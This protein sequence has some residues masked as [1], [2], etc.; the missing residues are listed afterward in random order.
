[1]S[2]LRRPD[3]RDSAGSRADGGAAVSLAFLRAALLV[4]ILA[5]EQLVD[6]RQ[7][8]DWQFFAVLVVAAAY[9][10][11]GLIVAVGVLGRSGARALARAQPGCD[12]LILA[13]LAYTSG[14]AF[15]DV[16]KAFFVIP[17]AA[18]FSE[19][20]RVTATWSLLAVA[21]FTL[22][23]VLAGGHPVGAQNS[24]QRLT[25]NQDL[26]LAW[27]GAAATML[28]V[29]LQRRTSRVE[30]LAA[31]RQ[32][33]VTHAIESVERERSRLASAL[34]DS[35][36]QNLIA[37][38][39]DLR[40]A[41][42]SG[43]PESFGRV[44]EA[45]DVTIAELREEIFNLHPHV[46]DHVGLGAALEQVARRYSHD[47]DLRV[48][49][50]VDSDEALAQSQVLFALGRELLGNAAKY[51]QASEVRLLVKL[52]SGC[53][54]LEVADDGCGI[55]LGRIRQ[56]LLE[57][58]IG[59]ASVSERVAA[60]RGTFSIT[61]APEAG[62]TVRVTLPVGESPTSPTTPEHAASIPP[63]ARHISAL[64]GRRSHPRRAE[65]ESGDLRL[66][67]IHRHP[68]GVNQLSLKRLHTGDGKEPPG[69][70]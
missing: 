51:A 41:Q 63:R 26:Y 57:G 52:E 69:V 17:L 25:I 42:R 34:H 45:I 35:P 5:C 40:R 70:R 67:D 18:A 36:V 11:A 6:G 7:L 13:T 24:W 20:S 66:G 61:T 31:S 58:H 27:T 65:P 47:G 55:P 15:S 43:D 22:Q 16:R 2:D 60:L 28:A 48:S 64:A 68:R 59:L 19:R 33:L 4:L 32:H 49:V 9:S 38:R 29:A 14:G 10:L 50:D 62:T 46:L 53:V 54:T 12:V 37:A 3:D 44:H 30:E 56:A 1:M 39:H 23:A 8:A 21:A